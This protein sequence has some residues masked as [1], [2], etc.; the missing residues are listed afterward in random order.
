[1]TFRGHL[2]ST[3]PALTL[4]IRTRQFHYEYDTRQIWTKCKCLVMNRPDSPGD[5]DALKQCAHSKCSLFDL[6][7]PLSK[8]QVSHFLSTECKCVNLKHLD[9]W[10][11]MISSSDVRPLNAASPIFSSPWLRTTFVNWVHYWNVL[12]W[13]AVTAWGM[14][15]SL[16]D[17]HPINASSPISTSPS[18][19]FIVVNCVHW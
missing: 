11:M 2:D 5:L 10:G 1:M 14:M 8:S 6:L 19:W 12:F 7:L 13:F 17:L 9:A 4:R 15:I 3:N 16:S 18:P